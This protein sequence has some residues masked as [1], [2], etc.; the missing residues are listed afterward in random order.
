[1][2][3]SLPLSLWLLWKYITCTQLLLLLTCV[4]MY[5][6]VCFCHRFHQLH[7]HTMGR[8]SRRR[9]LWCHQKSIPYNIVGSD[10]SSMCFICVVC[11]FAFDRW[12]TLL[13][14]AYL[15]S[16]LPIFPIVVTYKFL[17]FQ[18]MLLLWKEAENL[19]S[20]CWSFRMCHFSLNKLLVEFVLFVDS[21]S[22]LVFFIFV[23]IFEDIRYIRHCSL[24]I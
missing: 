22:I 23:S 10:L 11:V 1:M 3:L 13:W 4:W 12:L 14:S 17:A 6:C 16:F 24:F 8:H 5:V 19:N 2:S 9:P 20:L 15:I 18:T 7:G 21:S